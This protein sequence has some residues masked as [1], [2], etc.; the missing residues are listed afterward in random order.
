MRKF[1][2]INIHPLTT[3]VAVLGICSMSKGADYDF[4]LIVDSTLPGGTTP[5]KNGQVSVENLTAG[6]GPMVQ[7][8]DGN[9]M[10]T[11]AISGIETTIPIKYSLSKSG[12]DIMLQ[13]PNASNFYVEAINLK[14]Q[15]IPVKQNQQGSNLNLNFDGVASGWYGVTVFP[16]GDNPFKVSFVK[17]DN[18]IVG[19]SK[20]EFKSRRKSVKSENNTSKGVDT[21]RII[22]TPFANANFMPDTL[23][24]YKDPATLQS[25]EFWENT[26]DVLPNER[27]LEGTF[28]D[29]K[30]KERMANVD[31]SLKKKTSSGL[32][33]I[34]NTVTDA[35]G[36]Y[37]FLVDLSSIGTD[38]DLFLFS[39]KA[40]YE[41]SFEWETGTHFDAQIDKIQKSSYPSRKVFDDDAVL[42]G[43]NNFRWKF[44]H[45]VNVDSLNQILDEPVDSLKLDYVKLPEL[46]GWTFTD[47]NGVNFGEAEIVAEQSALGYD[48]GSFDVK[49]AFATQGYFLNVPVNTGKKTKVYF[50]KES[51][52][53]TYG[54]R[55]DEIPY[56]IELLS[57][58]TRFNSGLDV[59]DTLWYDVLAEKPTTGDYVVVKKDSPEAHYLDEDDENIIR[60]GHMF[61]KTLDKGSISSYLS[62]SSRTST[63]KEYQRMFSNDIPVGTRSSVMQG[64]AAEPSKADFGEFQVNN[65]FDEP[66]MYWHNSSTKGNTFTDPFQIIYGK[67]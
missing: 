17:K 57:E 50:M 15:K 18:V 58:F 26:C 36:E 23:Y 48:I 62:P 30:S 27:Y 19:T 51:E 13:V 3:A 22:S 63:L 31:L 40:G 59:T 25:T 11:F 41:N 7:N 52:D 24:V 38:E 56:G 8:Y 55:P 49:Q 6:I 34:A 10:A 42:D 46:G 12:N 28:R 9:G 16:E 4:T 60:N 61:Q 39:S 32:V 64:T 65:Q 66:N 53:P 1:R 67:K 35:N 47:Q 45:T 44:N 43:K 20:G 5:V 2:F 29:V 21:W 37:S 33:D 54:F 14:S